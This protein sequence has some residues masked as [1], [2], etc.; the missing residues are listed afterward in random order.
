[1]TA[2]H[3][4]APSAGSEASERDPAEGELV[5]REPAKSGRLF[6]ALWPS[7]AMQTALA[8]AAAPAVLEVL[9]GIGS[10]DAGMN[11]AAN[12][13]A[14]VRRVPAE[15][16]HL[17]LAFLGSVPLSRL[18][19][20]EQVAAHCAQ[21]SSVLDLPIDIT[22]DAIEHWRKPQVLVATARD[23]PRAAVALAEGLQR[24]LI[25]AGF[26][27]DLKAF[28]VH[29]TVA[30]KVR[31]GGRELHLDPVRWS[32]DSLHLVQSQTQPHG[33]VYRPLKKWVLD[34]RD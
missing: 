21:V 26:S 17:T 3:V 34:K 32:F 27:P 20:I 23:T 8:V 1:V 16:F 18:A 5:K 24:S 11:A 15:N 2:G 33:S 6:F 25:D 28:R 14:S 9:S 10:A 4:P 29:A 30:R 22:L 13:G 7:P 19:E 12:A 31:R